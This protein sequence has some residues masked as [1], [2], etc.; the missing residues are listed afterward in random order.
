MRNMVQSARPGENSGFILSQPSNGN[1][2]ICC[3]SFYAARP[4][5]I[6]GRFAGQSEVQ[7]LP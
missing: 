3:F 7:F 4:S 1:D 6:K 5:I 2:E